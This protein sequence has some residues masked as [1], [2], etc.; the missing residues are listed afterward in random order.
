MIFSYHFLRRTLCLAAASIC[1]LVILQAQISDIV[2]RVTVG[3]YRFGESLSVDVELLNAVALDRVEIAYRSFG[4]SSFKQLEMSVRGNIAS[5]VISAGDLTPPFM[6]YYL[7]LYKRGVTTAETYP[8]DNAIDHPLK[9]DLRAADHSSDPV[10]VLSPEANERVKP[11]DLF[12][13]FSLLRADSIINKSNIKTYLDDADIS[14]NAVV[15]DNLVVVRPAVPMN[16]G[17]HTIRVELFDMQGNPAHS[18]TWEFSV[19]GNEPT[20]QSSS[21][22]SAWMY[23]YSLQAETRNEN[24]SDVA[25]PFNRITA[26]A[27]ANYNQY[28]ILGSLYV[29]NEEKDFRQPQNRFFIGAQSSWLKLGYGDNYPSFPDLIMNGKRVRGF[30]GNLTLNSFNL[31]VSQGDIIRRVETDTLKTFPEDSLA[32]EQLRDSTATYGL[33][34]PVTRRWAKFSYGTFNRNVLAIRPSFGPRDGAHLGFTYLKSTDDVSSIRYGS[35]P[36]ENLVLG[37]DL[38]LPIDNRNIEITAQAA[39]SATNQDITNGSFT[40]QDI[41][42]IYNDHS[43]SDRTTIRR[44]RDI[45]S[46]FITVNEN[47]IPLNMKNLPTLAYEGGLSLNYFNN[48]FKSTY[49]RHG[50][51]FES[52]GQSFIRTDVVG[53][54]VSDRLGLVRNQVFLSGGFERLQDNTAETKSAT[55]TFTTTNASISYF[56]RTDLPNITVAYL[57]ASSI[58]DRNTDPVLGVDDKTNRFFVQLGKEFTP[59]GSKHNAMLGVS[60][61]TRDDQT[62]KNLDTKNTNISFSDRITFTIP[63]QLLLSVSSN[64]NTFPSPASV[65]TYKDS[66]VNYTTVYLNA[67]YRLMEDKLRLEGSLSPT[68][69]DIGRTFIDARVQYYFLRNVSLLSQLSLYMNK[70]IKNDII[71]SFILR[72]DV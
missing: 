41:D 59:G 11:E 36:Q 12:I 19:A 21:L 53:Y 15:S 57:L 70:N 60:A 25:T 67:Q 20:E 32:V 4:Q 26:S 65:S 64:S 52:F 33:Y 14:A 44:I 48:Y 3:E 39:I 63:L 9:I 10:I 51:N 31:D 45:V 72:A 61:S 24:I 43:E 16:V 1:S 54:T 55:T 29:T 56:P 46:R 2:S 5:G 18:L 27:G 7:L 71:W 6:E 37:S 40:D 28:K 22:S 66:T 17:K 49:L 50:N 47:L 13:S 23:N 58:N 34:D 38:L 69:G 8:I 42:S 35:H 68:F 62:P 30:T